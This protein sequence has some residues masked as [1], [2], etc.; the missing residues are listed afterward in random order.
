MNLFIF[1]CKYGVEQ[2]IHMPWLKSFQFRTGSQQVQ[3]PGYIIYNFV[4]ARA[5][6]EKRN[7]DSVTASLIWLLKG[8]KKILWEPMIKNWSIIGEQNCHCACNVRLGCSRTEDTQE[9]N[10]CLR[11]RENLFISILHA[12][13][14]LLLLFFFPK[15]FLTSLRPCLGFSKNVFVCS[16]VTF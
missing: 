15:A 6:A 14:C 12:L 13:L 2:E 10:C 9:D 11:A 5:H 16:A 3:P 1:H 7:P 8:G 4:R